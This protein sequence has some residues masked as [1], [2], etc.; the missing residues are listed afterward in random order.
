G[1]AQI[2]A[3]G[4]GAA[5]TGPRD[6]HKGSWLAAYLV[7][8]G[9]VAQCAL[10]RTQAS[11]AP[12]PAPGQVARV[13]YAS[14]NIGN[15]LVVVGSLTS[16]P[17][18]VDVGG[19]LL[20]PALVVAALTTRRSRGGVVLWGFRAVLLLLAVTMPIGLALAHLRS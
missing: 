3:G 13:Q 16:E 4:R 20:L 15:L 18:V 6:I 5:L 8:V 12:T 14:W 19:L 7:L 10:G 17:Y 11:L 1:G 2:V 9:G